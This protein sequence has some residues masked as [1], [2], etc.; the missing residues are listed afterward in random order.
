MSEERRG[1]KPFKL[2]LTAP[3][4]HGMSGWF[5][6][7]HSLWILPYSEPLLKHSR[8]CYK[9]CYY[10]LSN[11]H[12]YWSCKIGLTK[13]WLG[14]KVTPR[15]FI[16]L[17]CLLRVN[18]THLLF[19]FNTTQL[20][21]V[22]WRVGFLHGLGIWTVE[23]RSVVGQ[24]WEYPL[25]KGPLELGQVRCPVVLLFQCSCRILLCCTSFIV[26]RDQTTFVRN[27]N[28]SLRAPKE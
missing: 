1:K 3:T 10:N 14:S 16:S 21:W 23:D 19:Y 26:K 28:G 11:S 24:S 25:C 8:M 15:Y 17:T 27:S 12:V 7:N 13:L 18:V 22:G 4:Q 6:G 20:P 2:W 5:Y 9:N